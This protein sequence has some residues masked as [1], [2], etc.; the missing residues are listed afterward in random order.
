MTT[1]TPIFPERSAISHHLGV[2]LPNLL[3]G[4]REGLLV[5]CDLV[6][7]S[8]ASD[9]AAERS[10]IAAQRVH[11]PTQLV[12]VLPSVNP[13]AVNVLPV[14]FELLA[15]LLNLALSARRS[16]YKQCGRHKARG[17]KSPYIMH[18]WVLRLG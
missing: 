9:I 10:S 14:L 15:I 7:A 3:P 11:I 16:R 12:S 18:Y 13:V 6:R 1:L 17:E 5:R 4:S 8:T 2:I